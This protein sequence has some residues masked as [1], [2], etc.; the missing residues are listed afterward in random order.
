MNYY[1]IL[2]QA[3]QAIQ[4]IFLSYPR[5]DGERGHGERIFAYELYHQLRNIIPLEQVVIHGE[6]VKIP[7]VVA[8][9]EGRIEP[10]IIIHH[11]GDF[12]S[13]DLAIEI[14]ANPATINKNSVLQDLRK[15]RSYLDAPLNF[16]VVAFVLANVP[17]DTAVD[18]A[19]QEEAAEIE[20]ILANE[21]IH[22]FNVLLPDEF[23]D[24]QAIQ[25][26]WIHE[27]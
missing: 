6:Y 14:K 1:E 24:Y 27:L 21:N 2:L 10:D 8:G 22:V 19:T 3:F 20:A 9:L 7:G 17:F 5:A 15:V 16:D 26:A 25:P 12:E 4:V 11:P 23:E 18:G 13:Q